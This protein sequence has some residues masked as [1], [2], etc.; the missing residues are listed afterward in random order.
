[1]D[2][3]WS[4]KALN[5]IDGPIPAQSSFSVEVTLEIIDGTG[6]LV[7]FAE[8]LFASDAPGG[9]LRTDIDSIPDDVVGNENGEVKDDEVGNEEG[10]EDDHDLAMVRVP[11]VSLGDY[12]WYDSNADGLQDDEELGVQGVTVYLLDAN[13]NRTSQ[14]ASTDSTG[15]YSFDGLPLGTYAVEFDLST[16]P[17]NYAVT[18]HN[19]VT[20]MPQT[21]T[22]TPKQA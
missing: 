19:Q 15:Y 9:P 7:N 16:L 12:V 1:V 3:F 6:D 17:S 21:A 2:A 22:V 8:I 4:R 20:T 14:Q 10:D 5:T 18:L 11:E 13:G